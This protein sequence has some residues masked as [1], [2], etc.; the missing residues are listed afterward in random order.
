MKTHLKRKDMKDTQRSI[1]R[2]QTEFGIWGSLIFF[3]SRRV[4]QFLGS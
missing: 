2:I 4:A 3:F 1:L